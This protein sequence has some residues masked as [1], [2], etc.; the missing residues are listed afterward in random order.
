M[1]SA[2]VR[3]GNMGR[4]TGVSADAHGKKPLAARLRTPKP[5]AIKVVKAVFFVLALLPLARL[6]AGFFL[7]RLGANPIELITHSTGTWTLTFVLSTLSVTPLRQLTG[8]HWLLRLRRMFGLFA[9]F[10]VCLHFT[11]YIWF[12]QFFDWQA[13]WKD[14]LKR[15]FIWI[16]FGA[17]VMLIPLA[18]TSTNAAI[19]WV[20]APGWQRLH[21][22]VYVIAICGV[23]HY[24]WLVKKDVTQP[25]IY[26]SV[27]AALLAFRAVQAWRK[28]L[29]AP[30]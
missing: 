14:I 4:N 12:D 7:D 22:L 30:G 2:T 8:W 27:L 9:F 16:G 5:A 11:T 1:D 17:F 19:R 3:S 6:V 24:W 13:I 18:A 15:R 28:S 21:R 20:G 10:Y 29:S 23:V 25:L 26:G